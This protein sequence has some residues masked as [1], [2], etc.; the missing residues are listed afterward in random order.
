MCHQVMI[1][2]GETRGSL[3]VIEI[4]RHHYPMA[5]NSKMPCNY[6]LVLD[7]SLSLSLI[8]QSD[9]NMNVPRK[10]KR[11][12]IFHGWSCATVVCGQ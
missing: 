6:R 7:L 8:S 4:A 3:R 1:L 9:S 11:D 2:W 12:S 5:G 10:G